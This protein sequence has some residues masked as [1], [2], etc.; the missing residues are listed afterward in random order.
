MRADEL[1]PSQ[2]DD[3]EKPLATL[4]CE[5]TLRA[6][7]HVMAL[8]DAPYWPRRRLGEEPEAEPLEA[9]AVVRAEDRQEP[10]VGAETP[11]SQIL[12]R[13]T[14]PADA[15]VRCSTPDALSHAFRNGG[16]CV[17]VAPPRGPPPGPLDRP[18]V[19]T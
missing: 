15:T 3:V 19:L 17:R 5:Q 11:E 2:L 1:R 18:H 16:A 10:A 4:A 12:P 13:S 8:Y 14:A 9:D 7:S 6:S